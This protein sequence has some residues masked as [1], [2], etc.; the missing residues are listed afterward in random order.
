M[1]KKN[2][3]ILLL[4]VCMLT[5]A[6][7][8]KYTIS[9]YIKETQSQ[10]LLLGA[11]VYIVELKTGTSA[12]TY[13][14]F[15]ITVPKGEYTIK[16]SYVG[17]KT[18][19]KKIILD[20]NI[21]LDISL[22]IGQ[23][24]EEIVVTADK[25]NKQSEDVRT[26]VISLPV[27][28]IKEIPSFLGEKDVLK[29]IQLM[30]GVQKG[31]EGQS[32][33]YVRGGGPDQNL[34]ILDD[35]P[36]YNA[37][38]LFGFFSVFNGDALRSVELIKG[39]FP[40][41]YGG[42]LSSVIDINMKDGNKEHYTGE[43]G[44]GLVSSR[45]VLEG[46]IVKDKSS[47][48]IS[49][50]RTYIDVL[51]MPITKSQ[52]DGVEAGYYFYDLNAKVNY[53][54]NKKNKLYLSGY[55]GRDIFYSK[56]EEFDMDY[57]MG[58][59]N[60][61]GTLRWN[62]QFNNKL[63]ANTSIIYSK[64][65]FFI[66]LEEEFDDKKYI[67]KYSSGIEDIG[68]KID[69]NYYPTPK[70]TIYFGLAST[71][72]EFTPRAI[73][74][75][76][77]YMPDD[78]ERDEIIGT[79]ESGAYIED[80]YKPFNRMQILG[81]LRY[82]HYMHN[83]KT[84]DMFE[85]R[86]STSYKLFD[87]FAVKASYAKMQQYIHLLSNTGIGLPTDLWVPSTKDVEPQESWQ[88]AGGIAK[89]FPNRNLSLTVEGYYKEMDNIIGYKEGANFMLFDETSSFDEI[90]WQRMVTTGRSWS[91]GA[92]I[93]LQRKVGK[94]SGWLG[95][96]LSWTKMKFPELN[97]GKEYW[98]KYDRRHDFSAV[99]I[100]N[101]NKKIKLGATW[102]Y[103]TGNAMSLPLSE[104]SGEIHNPTPYNNYYSQSVILDE[105]P[106]RNQFRMDPYHRLDLNIQF[107]KKKKRG[108]RTWEI[109]IYNVY[110]RKNPFFYYVNTNETETK[111]K[112][113]SLF[114]IL[115]SFSYS[116]NFN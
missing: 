59:G 100:Y 83:S 77:D 27:Q 8:Q 4:L 6:Y 45:A 48:L 20:K 17:Y 72:H 74:I 53:D 86:I 81:G 25:I 71:Y 28:Q 24:L 1:Y 39:G 40:A 58:W 50:R 80:L 41:R 5:Q 88:I 14:F 67:L 31:T 57:R 38:H 29:V 21:S 26:S 75:K 91:Y 84:Y 69:F 44:I 7:S 105:Y 102:V 111:V 97:F 34:L 9:G 103:A 106:G 95:Y 76:N 115:P 113:V 78:I 92:E 35:A 108:T 18:E 54:I 62:H 85:P 107:N 65:N 51:M 79:V 55:F 23:E 12:N 68:A 101:V 46:P 19:T 96:T 112:Q 52:T 47:F 42:R 61:T 37:Q 93:L 30:P 36:V 15:S 90:N 33:I 109:S 32:G 73:V 60:Q 56:D 87:D 66:D 89:D 22:S 16:Y 82:S 11:T 116:F 64:Y 70:H 104:Y 13:G 99:L 114:P 3:T 110:N 94:L 98:A 2:F 43:L 49:G 63:F 10:E